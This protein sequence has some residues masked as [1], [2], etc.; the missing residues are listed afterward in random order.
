MTAYD[1]F[2]EKKNIAKKEISMR[3]GV[4]SPLASK[5]L[6]FGKQG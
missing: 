1:N 6:E 3:T 2:K 5:N 4:S